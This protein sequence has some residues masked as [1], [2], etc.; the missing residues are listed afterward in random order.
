MGLGREVA[1]AYINIHG[2]LS[3]FRKDIERGRAVVSDQGELLADDFAEAMKKQDQKNMK[4]RWSALT[5]AFY[6]GK[7]LDW[8]RVLG[9]FDGASLGKQQKQ[10]KAFLQDMQKAGYMTEEQYKD[11]NRSVKNA[12][13]TIGDHRKAQA[14]I[15]KE[16]ADAKLMQDRYNLSLKGMTEAADLDAFEGRWKKLGQTLA[17]VNLDGAIGDVDWSKMQKGTSSLEDFNDTMNDTIIRARLLGRV[18]DEQSRNV[19]DAL[20]RYIDAEK[21]RAKSIDESAASVKRMKSEADRARISLTGMMESAKTKQLEDDF[22]KIAAAMA[23]TNWGPV[24]KDHASMDAFQKKT[25]DVVERMRELGRVSDS[26]YGKVRRTLSDITQHASKFN[27]ELDK[28]GKKFK[29][30]RSAVD[31]MGKSW[32]RT[33]S[34]VRLVVTAIAAGASDLATIGSGLSGSATALVSSFAMAAGSI[35]PLAAAAGG[36]GVAIGLM[37]SGMDDLKAKFPGVQVAMDNIGKTWQ[38]QAKSFGETWGAS[39]ETLLSNFNSQLGKYDFGTPMGE[40]ISRVTESF[41]EFMMGPGGFDS[42]LQALSTDL[43]AAVQGFGTGFSGVFGALF[44]MLSAA[45]PVAAKLGEDFKNWGLN[46]GIATEKARASGELTAMFDRMRES[47]LVVLDFVGSLGSALGT[48]FSLGASSGNSMLRSLTGIVDQFNAWM[49]TEAGRQT[50]LDWFSSAEQIVRSMEPLVVG[51][52]KALAILVTPESIAMVANLMQNLG[53]LMPILGQ[54]LEAISRLGIFNIIVAALLAV[55][56]AL[57]PI[58]PSIGKLAGL[59]GDVLMTAIE[60]L[61]PILVELV[62]AFAPIIEAVVDLAAQ[63]VPILIPAIR[64]FAEVLKIGISA[65][66]DMMQAA[67]DFLSSWDNITN[68]FNGAATGISDFNNTVNQGLADFWNGIGAKIAEWGAAFK[69]GWDSFWGGLGSGIADIWTGITTNIG[70]GLEAL[71]LAFDTWITNL[72]T[73]WDNFWN[74]LGTAVAVG[75]GLLTTYLQTQFDL[76]LQWFND[77]FITPWNQFWTAFWQALPTEM[78]TSLTVIWAAIV[79]FFTTTQQNFTNFVTT[80]TTAWNTFWQGLATY[81]S[82]KWNE[83]WGYINTGVA[84]VQATIDGF[85]AAVNAAWNKFWGDVGKVLSDAWNQFTSF[86]SDGTNK[87][88][89]VIQA[90]IGLI[91]GRWNSFWSDVANNVSNGWNSIMSNVQRGVQI[92]QSVIMG[93]VS[94]ITGRWNS[95]WS[96][97]SSTAGRMMEA[98]RVVVQVGMNQVGQFFQELPGRAGAALGGMVGQLYSVGTQMIQGLINGVRNMAGAVANAAKGVVEGAINGAK[99]LLGIHSPSRVFMEIG[100]FTGEGMAIGLDQMRNVVRKASE[101]IADVAVGAFDKSKMYVAGLDAANGLASG[102]ASN[103]SKIASAMG[104]LG[105]RMQVNGAVGIMTPKFST[106]AASAPA[107]GI[108]KQVNFT[109][110]AIQVTTQAKNPETVAGIL[111]DD[112]VTTTKMG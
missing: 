45:A 6:S 64:I 82:E 110:G 109:E 22:K 35:V 98:L 49:H 61:T 69:A 96:D 59:I 51:L 107:A 28:Q 47:L 48:V 20:D 43:P 5:K 92:V 3:K 77:A 33:D 50:M 55:G 74:G 29:L 67:T 63:L 17:G 38:A 13:I 70:L 71:R 8:D 78:Q 68:A 97:V 53:E 40:A 60:E 30:I 99:A 16:V 80:V 66:G 7:K 23:S 103:K 25:I 102:L 15:T 9:Q 54:I 108:G 1:D 94:L 91:I 44:S 11:A 12:L 36:M 100:N 32:Q 42:F 76:A 73:G 52:G 24:A 90:F 106:P 46:L 101:N 2:D 87:V 104:A 27:V 58:M 57:E 14:G 62:G 10:I 65:M 4:D 112:I 86:V 21:D 75:W 26:E 85:A 18:T 89:T 34:T 111:L 84:V 81:V 95:F 19:L 31:K 37:V 93:F 79:A 72:R 83:M 39:L 41:N 56:K 88:S 105:D